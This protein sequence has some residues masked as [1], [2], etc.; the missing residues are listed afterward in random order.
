MLPFKYTF[1]EKKEIVRMRKK[2]KAL[3][4]QG[5][6]LYSSSYDY[7]K[8]ISEAVISPDGYGVYVKFQD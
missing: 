4:D 2:I 8:K 6:K 7:N 3:T 5:F 1:S